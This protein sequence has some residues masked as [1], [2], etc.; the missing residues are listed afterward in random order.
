MHLAFAAFVALSFMPDQGAKPTGPTTTKEADAQDEEGTSKSSGRGLS[1]RTVIHGLMVLFPAI[2]LVILIVGW[3]QLNGFVASHSKLATRR[4]VGEFKML[5][6]KH[7][8]LGRIIRPL[9]LA[10]TPLQ[11]VLFIAG[12][13]ELMDL[14]WTVVPSLVCMCVGFAMKPA[15]KAVDAIPVGDE[16]K[17]LRDQIVEGWHGN[18]SLPDV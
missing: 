18:G 4:D 14:A 10:G 3:S 11:I 1:I 13:F 12:E 15:Q 6:Q 5:A 8:L 9:L 17:R 16:V 7:L 2:A